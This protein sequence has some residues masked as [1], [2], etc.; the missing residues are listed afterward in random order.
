MALSRCTQAILFSV[1]VHGMILGG[2]I[3]RIIPL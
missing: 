2:S 3:L 1:A